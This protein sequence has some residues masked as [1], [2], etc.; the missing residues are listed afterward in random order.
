[1]CSERAK[2]TQDWSQS[3]NSVIVLHL[4]EQAGGGLNQSTI[5]LQDPVGVIQIETL[6]RSRS[7]LARLLLLRIIGMT[8][9]WT[10]W[11]S[12]LRLHCS[13]LRLL[14]WVLIYRTLL[15]DISHRLRLLMHKWLWL[16]PKR[17]WWG[18]RWSYMSVK[19]RYECWSSLWSSRREPW[20][21]WRLIWTKDLKKRWKE[22][23]NSL[24]ERGI[25]RMLSLKRWLD[26]RRHYWR[27]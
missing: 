14:L 24:K 21:R 20:Q 3:E 9:S 4:M 26:R 22:W 18:M 11:I 15:R 5:Y 17:R 2:I 23:S 19:K 7:T 13:Q 12:R 16:E 8:S 25:R 10:S 1:M 27:K 6:L